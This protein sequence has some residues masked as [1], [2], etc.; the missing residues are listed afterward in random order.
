MRK[1][2]LI[3]L[4]LSSLMALED[5]KVVKEDSVFKN[6]FDKKLKEQNRVIV[7]MAA[8]EMRKHLPQKVDKYTTLVSAD[9]KDTTLIYIYELSVPKKSDADLKKEGKKRLEGQIKR[10]S[11][12]SSKRFLKS[13]INLSYV[14]KSAKTKK[15]LFQIDVSKKDCQR[16]W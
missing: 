12:I 4:V 5:V 13:D 16:L 14:Y 9:Y 11:C 1:I 6:M 15:T 8:E 3:S 2:F 10:H 7:K